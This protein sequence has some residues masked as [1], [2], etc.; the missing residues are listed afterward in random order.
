MWCGVLVYTDTPRFRSFVQPGGLKFLVDLRAKVLDMLRLPEY[1]NNA[2]LVAMDG[3]FRVRVRSVYEVCIECVLSEYGVY[4]L[5]G[6]FLNFRTVHVRT[7]T[8]KHSHWHRTRNCC[9]VGLQSASL[10]S[11]K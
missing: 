8:Y 9:Q 5:V 6:G 1:R 7:L 10:S 3:N 2:N 11:H 4:L